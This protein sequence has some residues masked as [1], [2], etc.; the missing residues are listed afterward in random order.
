MFQF[1]IQ[2]IVICLLVISGKAFAAD[3]S[4]TKNSQKLATP[5]QIQKA[6]E[7]NIHVQDVNEILRSD[8]DQPLR[9]ATDFD[10]FKYLLMSGQL[11]VADFDSTDIK[12]KIAQNLPAGM[13]LILLVMPGDEASTREKFKKWISADRLI[14]ATHSTAYNGFWARDAYPYPVYMNNDLTVRLVASNYDREFSGHSVLVKSIDAENIMKKYKHVFVGGNLLADETGRCFVVESQRLYGLKDKTL[15]SA[16][17]CQEVVRFKHKQGIGDVDEVIK[18][19]PRKK[20]LTNEESYVEKLESLGYEVIRLPKLS[21]YRTYA[22]SIILGDL[23]FMPS[24]SKE[25]DEEAKKVYE[26]LGYRVIM[27]D[28]R[29]L[30]MNGLGSIHC[31]TMAYPEVNLKQ[32]MRML[33]ARIL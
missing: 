31:A 9:P 23:V 14:I 5:E 11:K 25:T 26:G 24:F 19:L 17:G 8:D 7:W 21:K 20:V 6:L 22:N 30:S 15:M 29:T 18:V 4:T 12:M 27:A 13:K 1:L 28:S 3:V 16:Y 10:S 2:V 33:G 32:L